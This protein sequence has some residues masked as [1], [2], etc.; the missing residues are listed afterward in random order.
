MADKDATTTASKPAS[1]VA[2]TKGEDS[3]PFHVLMLPDGKTIDSRREVDENL[4]HDYLGK[5]YEAYKTLY[6]DQQVKK[7]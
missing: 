4:R 3:S 6:N 1:A 2:S 7:E 5:R